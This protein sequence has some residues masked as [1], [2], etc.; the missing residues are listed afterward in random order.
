LACHSGDDASFSSG[1]NLQLVGDSLNGQVF[2]K[3]PHQLFERPSDT[4]H[5]L[6]PQGLITR[7][8]QGIAQIDFPKRTVKDWRLCNKGKPGPTCPIIF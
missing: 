6:H 7:T 5:R 4:C 8:S 1:T 2:Q 3:R